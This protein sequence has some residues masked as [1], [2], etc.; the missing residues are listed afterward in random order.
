MANGSGAWSYTTGALSGG[1]HVVTATATDV[2]GNTGL[3]SLAVNA[4]IPTV[5]ESSGATSLTVVGNVYHFGDTSGSGPTLKFGGSAITVGQI[6]AWT[7]IAVEQTAGGYQVAWKAGNQFTIWTTDSSGNYISNTPTVVGTDASL[8]AAEATFQQDLNGDGVISSP[9]PPPPPSATAIESSGSTILTAVGNKYYLY[10]SAGTG[11]SVKLSGVD[12]TAGQLSG[13]TPVGAEQ[14]ASGYQLAWKNT[15]GTFLLWTT[16]SNGNYVSDPGVQSATSAAVTSAE[17]VLH[18]DLNGDG[19][20]GAP[21]PPP[22]P[23]SATVIESF[24]ATDLTVVSNQYHFGDSSGSGPTLKFQ[25]GAITVGQIG[26][27]TPFAVE[28]VGSGYQVAWKAGGLYTIW[29]TDS[30]GNYVSNTAAV[31]GTD[32]SIK[33]AE[34]TFQQDLNG[35][36]TIDG[37]VTLTQPPP[38]PPPPPLPPPPSNVTVIESFGATDL[39]VVSNQYHFGDSSGSGPTLKFQGGAITVGQIG[40][41]NPIGVE[42]TAS[43]YQVA[44]KAGGLYTIWT[45]DS[46]GNYISNTAAAAG[47]DRPSNRPRPCCIRISTATASSAAVARPRRRSCPAPP[48]TMC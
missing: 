28:Q 20:I 4:A 31:A 43:G 26:A 7:P 32:A 33:S 9:P 39:T 41:W 3:A 11:P 27:W 40:S 30:S 8:K 47:T 34:A 18:Q 44:W 37:T 13:W 5:V 29:T 1:T 14:T 48:A 23:S 35:D 15:N 2:A 10:N 45:T 46:S 36:G 25:G 12:V 16:D 21:P 6:G 24:G 19:I 17:N 38:P 22:P 42:Q